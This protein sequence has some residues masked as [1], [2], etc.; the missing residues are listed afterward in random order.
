MSAPSRSLELLR[1]IILAAIVGFATMQVRVNRLQLQINEA[2]IQ[3][4][5]AVEKM[6]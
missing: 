4:I 1:L 3:R 6:R 2:L 5:R